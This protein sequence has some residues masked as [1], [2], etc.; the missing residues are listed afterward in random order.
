MWFCACATRES[1]GI[2][3]LYAFST[4]SQIHILQSVHTFLKEWVWQD[5]F[6]SSG[7]TVNPNHQHLVLSISK[8]PVISLC[9]ANVLLRDTQA[10]HQFLKATDRN[11]VQHKV[12]KLMSYNEEKW[13]KKERQGVSL[14]KKKTYTHTSYKKY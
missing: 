4:S 8:C 14:I 11:N 13:N 6:P 7:A 5:A 3:L 2:L 1:S 12:N 10:T 9:P